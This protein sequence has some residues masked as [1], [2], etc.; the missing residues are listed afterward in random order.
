MVGYVDFMILL[1]DIPVQNRDILGEI[2]D[3]KILQNH[4]ITVSRKMATP[5][6]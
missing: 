1:Q 4:K 3:A 5:I 6:S 2:Q